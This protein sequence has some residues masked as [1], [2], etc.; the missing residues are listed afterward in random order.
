MLKTFVTGFAGTE[1]Q[2]RCIEGE[3]QNQVAGSTK[4]P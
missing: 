3:E 2:H 1:L 4:K